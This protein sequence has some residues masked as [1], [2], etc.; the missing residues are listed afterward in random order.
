MM[1]TEEY[2]RT[3]VEYG[4]TAHRA[5]MGV[6]ESYS[7]SCDLYGVD[8]FEMSINV[9]LVADEENSGTFIATAHL[10]GIEPR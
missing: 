1:M 2:T 3:F 5:L 9:H 6:I 8:P 10:S 4:P 7:A